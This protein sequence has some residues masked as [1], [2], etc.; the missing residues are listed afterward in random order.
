MDGALSHCGPS[1]P[2]LLEQGLLDRHVLGAQQAAVPRE[3]LGH[4]I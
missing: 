3:H 1:V 2:E 4:H